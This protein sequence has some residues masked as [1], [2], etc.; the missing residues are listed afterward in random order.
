MGPIPMLPTVAVSGGDAAGTSP[1]VTGSYPYK[2]AKSGA[3][4]HVPT[5]FSSPEIRLRHVYSH[6][7]RSIEREPTRSPNRL[8]RSG[9]DL[10]N[11][12][13]AHVTR[14]VRYSSHPQSTRNG[15]IVQ[16]YKTRA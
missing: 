10:Q 11:K 3:P 9:Y 5:N 13:R 2:V 7:A 1:G 12:T 4:P 16:R 14:I 8:P 6:V 15:R